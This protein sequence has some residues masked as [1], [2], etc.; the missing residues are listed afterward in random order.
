SLVLC[1]DKEEAGYVYNNLQSLLPG[2]PIH[3]LPDSFRQRQNFSR[4]DR[5][6]LLLKTET[7]NQ[8]Y[9]DRQKA[10]LIVTYPEAVLEKV[11]SPTILDKNRINL[12]IGEEMDAELL[13][14]ELV[15]YGF[16]HVD[17]VYEPGEFSVRGGI[18]DV[19][20]YG[21]EWPYRVELFDTEIESIR[22]FD[23]V[24]QL[25]RERVESI[26][27]V[28]DIQQKVDQED[29]ASFFTLIRND[30][31]L[32]YINQPLFRSRLDMTYEMIQGFRPEIVKSDFSPDVVS[33]FENEKYFT[34]EEV[35]SEL[36]EFGGL[37]F[38][39]GFKLDLSAESR[40]KFNIRP[41]PSFN[42]NFSL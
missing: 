27:I 35:I 19:F 1:S 33:F 29:W 26:S 2:K 12:R 7:A 38:E 13:M 21:N 16:Q 20:T 37:F 4:I 34:P 3:F 36:E 25:S 18:V 24:N 17:F 28:P 31:V 5:N 9:Q 23:P 41:Q 14:S 30:A 22:L 8:L 15:E 40:E 11:V 39:D 6:N 32:C 10:H 42:K